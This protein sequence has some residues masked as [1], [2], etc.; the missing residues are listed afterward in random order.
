MLWIAANSYM[1][2]SQYQLGASKVFIRDPIHL[3]AL[4]EMRERK[5]NDIVRGA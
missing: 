4:E 3:F 2:G 1:E 5:L